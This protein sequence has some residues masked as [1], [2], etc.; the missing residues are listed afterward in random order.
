MR[1]AV[2]R[3]RSSKPHSAAKR[4]KTGTGTAAAAGQGSAAME[5]LATV[6]AGA[7]GKPRRGRRP[8]AAAA[9]AAAAAAVDETAGDE[10]MARSLAAAEEA[11]VEDMTAELNDLIDEMRVSDGGSDQTV[12]SDELHCRTAFTFVCLLSVC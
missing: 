11:E 12:A 3:R 8:G 6:A 1:K 7:A 2:V 5:L 4:T 10:D 9:A